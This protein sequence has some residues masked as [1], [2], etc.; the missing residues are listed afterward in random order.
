MGIG[1]RLSA[2]RR[3]RPQPARPHHEPAGW[4]DLLPFETHRIEV[5][6]GVWTIDDERTP[7]VADARTMLVLQCLGGELSGRSVVDLAAGEGGFAFAFARLGAERVVGIETDATAIRRAELARSLLGLDAV[8][9]VRPVQGDPVVELDR[10]GRFDVVFAS[11]ALHGRADPSAALDAIGRV[12]TKVALIDTHVAGPG[13]ASA[14]P[15]EDELAGMLRAAG[16]SRIGRVDPEVVT[17]GRVWAVDQTNR[18]CYLA[19][20]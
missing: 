9:L 17:N 15:T 8:E 14:W 1:D 11:G 19:W 4:W 16:F 12:C 20:V 7:P 3:P 5:A 13:T 2:L 6:P 18:V 10:L